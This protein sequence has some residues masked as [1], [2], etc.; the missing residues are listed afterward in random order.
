MAI[1]KD[2]T[3]IFANVLLEESESSIVQFPNLSSSLYGFSE[4]HQEK[5]LGFRQD[6]MLE[7]NS[8]TVISDKFG[9]I[10][11]QFMV[12]SDLSPL[13]SSSV[14]ANSSSGF[15]FHAPGYQ[16]E[17]AD[18]HR[19]LMSFE[20]GT[21]GSNFMHSSGCFL[22]FQQACNQR[23]SHPNGF[24]TWEG[25]SING[26][27]LKV[28][29]SSS[30]NLRVFDDIITS[31]Q[32]ASSYQ[33]AAN[34]WLYAAED[35]TMAD[36]CQASGTLQQTYF[37]KRPRLEEESMQDAKKQCAN[38]S[39]KTKPKPTTSKDPQTIAAKNRRERISERLK[40]LQDLIPNGS[41]V[42]LVTMLEK[43]ISYVKFLQ[44][45]VKVLE[46]DEFW[47]AVGGK[48][49]DISQVREAIDAILASQRHTATSSS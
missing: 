6:D 39:K 10:S 9:R 2:R 48:P 24:S 14:S 45:Q 16:P 11:N 4:Y 27:Q 13:S 35:A 47:P 26:S 34:D 43:A 20:T 40:I 19:S 25:S 42:D 30:R 37:N 46:T 44:L 7:E 41:K 32:T 29:N 17:E 49:P 8:S 38:G 5:Q 22:S 21:N 18:H 33:D 1:A 28:M 31:M 36:I 15:T 23:I 3:P 12:M